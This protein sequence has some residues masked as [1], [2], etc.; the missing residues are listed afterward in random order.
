VVKVGK[1]QVPGAGSRGSGDAREGRGAYRDCHI[2]RAEIANQDISA[3]SA[4]IQQCLERFSQ[5]REIVP[6]ELLL[7]GYEDRSYPFFLIAEVRAWA[8]KLAACRYLFSVITETTIAW[9]FPCLV[10]LEMDIG[11]QATDEQAVSF[12]PEDFEKL[13]RI[14]YQ[15]GASFLATIAKDQAEF[16]RLALEIAPRINSGLR[17]PGW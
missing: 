13:R 15:N 10:P 8:E 3:A 4:A 7:D 1:P 12:D 2:S 9:L 6:I 17:A 11:T 14:I 16:D 5:T